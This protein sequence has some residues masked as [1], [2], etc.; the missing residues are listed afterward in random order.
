MQHEVIMSRRQYKVIVAGSRTA[1]GS[2]IYSLLAQKLDR[3]LRN[4]SVT[5]DI[6]IVS[7]T[8]QGADIMGEQYAKSRSYQ[9]E[10]YP[11][12]WDTFG[13]RAGYLR[14]EDMALNADALVALWDG[15]SRGTEHMIKLAKQHNL[16]TRVLQF[17]TARRS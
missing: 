4:K 1:T 16:P 2:Y 15:N 11:A 8:A 7:G 13:K 9:V 12:D 5:H 6:V 17:T 3:I 14:N 10:R